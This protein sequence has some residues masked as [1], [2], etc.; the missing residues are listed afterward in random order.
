MEKKLFGTDGV[1]GEANRELTAKLVFEL[2]RAG[3][4]VLGHH[5]KGAMIAVGK[6]TRL[7]GDLLEAALSAGICSVGCR[8]A[9]LGII[10]T[11]AVAYLTRVLKLPAGVVISA[12][13]NPMQDNGIKFF[14]GDGYKLSDETEI[15]IE[16]LVAEA[17][18]KL[19][20]PVGEEV[21]NIHE[22]VEA[23]EVYIKHLKQT[24]E[25]DFK[26]LK[27]VVDCANGAA[28]KAAPGVL[29]ELGAEVTAINDFPNGVNINDNCGST[30]PQSL[31]RAVLERDADLGF[32]H[33]GDADRVLAVDAEGNLVDGDQI[34]AMCALQLKKEGKLKGN[35][36][37]ATVM[38]NM[39][40][41]LALQEAGIAVLKT[42]VG[43]RYVLEK[44]IESGAVLGGEQSGHIIF[45][46]YNTTGDGLITAL[47][48]LSVMQ[49]SGRSLKELAS[50]I[51]QLPQFLRNVRVKDKAKLQDN[52]NVWQA[53]ALAECKLGKQGRVLLRPSGTEPLVR[54][55]GEGMDEGLIR[56]IIDELAEVVAKELG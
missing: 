14:G 46:Q 3:A 26:G 11:P 2:G 19:P 18:D 7:S 36:I 53:V 9:R 41:E 6:D 20:F 28:Y 33:D 12:S 31:Q 27:V 16:D 39:G 52:K 8:V 13:H 43:D 17:E 30:N 4:Y 55:M 22:I 24:V 56:Q 44:M 5:Q 45:L 32:A 38:S 54:V 23:T 37:V 49:K 34:M 25:V 15:E 10:P 21:G 40:L 35:H 1:R 29:Q 48:V 50:Q 47:Q 42:Q 51:H